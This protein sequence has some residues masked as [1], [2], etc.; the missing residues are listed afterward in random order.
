M[1]TNHTSSLDRR[2][3]LRL[4]GLTAAGAAVLAACGNTQAG[5][6][7]RVGTGATQPTLAEAPVT[8]SVL[9]RTSAAYENSIAAAY[10]RILDGGYAKDH[11]DLV[12]AFLEHHTKAAETFN[13]L[14]TGFGGEAWTCG[15]TRL[16][17]AYIN[18]IFD[19]VLKGA[20]A[21]DQAA[22]IE[23]SD[24]V[25]RDMINLVLTLENL[26]A[27]TSQALVPQITDPAARGEAMKVGARS[28]RQAALVALRINPKAYVSGSPAAQPA[29]TTTAAADSGPAQTE[30]PLPIAIPSTFGS[31]SGI[32]YIGG[33]GDENGVRMKVIFETPSLN[34]LAYPFDTCA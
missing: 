8:D 29:P 25:D 3:L 11:T 12:T 24:D 1:T 30:I 20:P 10:K 15:S 32:T 18:P 14:A 5:E 9:A 13:T 33:K 17:A 34:S 21:T 7:G 22:A 23:P 16:D 2:G 31:L 28:A 19:R 27:E 26:S 4:G 6:I